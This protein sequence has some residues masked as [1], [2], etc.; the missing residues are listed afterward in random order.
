M[1]KHETNNMKDQISSAVKD[2]ISFFG[3]THLG[4]VTIKIVLG[5]MFQYGKFYLQKQEIW[6]QRQGRVFLTAAA[7]NYRSY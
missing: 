7:E 2:I 6:G 3:W 5:E 1:I 4:F